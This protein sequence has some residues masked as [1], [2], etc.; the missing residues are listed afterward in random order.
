[1]MES[2]ILKCIM[3]MSVL[4]LVLASSLFASALK[5][6]LKE[7]ISLA[8]RNNPQVLISEE[9]RKIA[10]EKIVEAR[11]DAFP[12]VKATADYNRLDSSPTFGERGIGLE[13]NFS[14]N[15]GL[16]QP[17]YTGGKVWSAVKTANMFKEYSD[18]GNEVTRNNVI[19]S[20]KEGAYRILSLRELVKIRA[21]SVSLAAELL[22]VTKKKFDAEL[23]SR[24]EVLRAE[25]KLANAKPPLIKTKNELAITRDSF[26]K[27]LGL[28]LTVE[29]ELQGYLSYMPREIISLGDAIDISEKK[30]PDLNQQRMIR[31]MKKENINIAKSGHRPK[32]SFFANYSGMYPPFGSQE[33]EWDWGWN[34]GI[35]AELLIFNGFTTKSQ[36][37][38]ASIEMRKADII[39]KDMK[40]EVK[41][42]IRNALNS[43]QDAIQL[44]TSQEKN[45]EQAKEGLRIAEI[46]Y[47]NEVSPQIEVLD[48][49][50]A[51][52]FAQ[53]NRLQ[54]IFAYKIAIAKLDL[55]MGEEM[56]NIRE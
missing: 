50:V 7:S 46:R 47:K 45:V 26:K 16:E 4:S 18:L 12:E 29:I 6:N 51:L 40:E 41:L 49:Q 14:V 28:D 13:D 39:Y 1:M 25:V 42:E 15:L 19:Y 30:R 54:A 8:L 2:R 38:Q 27:L 9:E 48:A 31:E 23:V 10:D 33:R 5:L 11:G 43:I 24:Y 35:K 52:A 21:E 32:V 55:A 17:L 22:D 56:T 53:V 37:E 20:T 3:L 36:V 34:T 44:I